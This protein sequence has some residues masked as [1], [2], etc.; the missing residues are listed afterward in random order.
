MQSLKLKHS[1]FSGLVDHRDALDRY[2]SRKLRFHLCHPFLFRLFLRLL[3]LLPDLV[4]VVACPRNQ[5]SPV[6]RS[7]VSLQ[8]VWPSKGLL[9][10]LTEVPWKRGKIIKYENSKKIYLEDFL[11]WLGTEFGLL[12]LFDLGGPPAWKQLNRYLEGTQK[13]Q[14]F[15]RRWD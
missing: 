14:L 2:S 4:L 10:H 5:L 11:I 3:L 15:N 7:D 13:I 1:S 12:Y 6:P 9:A 8:V